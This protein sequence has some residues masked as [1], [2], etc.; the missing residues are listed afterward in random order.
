MALGLYFQPAGFTPA[1]YDEVLE[2]LDAAGA[3]IGAVPG[4]TFHCA[5]DVDGAIAVFDIWE[6]QE[7][8]ERFG[9]TLLPIMDKLGVDPG[10]PQVATIHNVQPG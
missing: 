4:R 9:E 8:F 7:Q 2:Q 6:S 1:I 3:G 10:Q 5:M